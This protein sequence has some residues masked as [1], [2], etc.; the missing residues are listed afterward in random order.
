MELS[1]I[2]KELVTSKNTVNQ[3]G[4][5]KEIETKIILIYAFNATGKTQL[6]VA[7]KNATKQNNQHAGVYYNAY[8]EDLFVWENETEIQLKLV[9]SS[10]NKFHSLLD[11]EK[12]REKLRPF[13]PIYDFEFVPYAD[14]EKGIE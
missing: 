1:D 13:K 10:L 7:Y 8:S 3:K 4:G 6:S 9:H 11:E 12:I 14:P 5:S 2:A